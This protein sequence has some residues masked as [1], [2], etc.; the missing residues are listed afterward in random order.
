MKRF[1]LLSVLSGGS[2][3]DILYRNFRRVFDEIFSK[4]KQVP[5]DDKE[6][7]KHEFFIKNKALFDE[8]ETVRADLY[9]VY[10]FRKKLAPCVLL[11]SFMFF[12]LIF[13]WVLKN[14]I[15]NWIISISL[16]LFIALAAAMYYYL[17][18]PKYRYVSLYKKAFLPKIVKE[19]G[20][21]T[22]EHEPRS[23]INIR[24]FENSYIVYPHGACIVEDHLKGEYK[25]TSIEISEIK[26]LLPFGVSSSYEYVF[27]GMAIF[28]DIRKKRFLGKTV[29]CPYRKELFLELDHHKGL[30]RIKFSARD[31]EKVFNVFGSDQVEAHYLVDPAMMEH[32]M[33]LRET[34]DE[35]GLA[36]SFYDNKVL[37]M[38]SGSHNH[39]EPADLE[40]PA[41]D[42]RSILSMKKEIGEILSL[43]D[44]LNLYDPRDVHQDR[45]PLDEAI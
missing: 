33:H 32:L 27:R 28:I 12:S 44:R 1:S 15:G 14:D 37:I 13:F 3:F 42:P 36:A 38:M 29:I 4:K 10:A 34:C 5:I 25:G 6:E 8:L 40:I 21:F 22:Y 11:L 39:F 19:I 23:A 7:G 35:R 16:L 9:Q 41:T 18:D 45:E 20:D 31:F 17:V 26:L 43:I 2:I 30:K 24:D